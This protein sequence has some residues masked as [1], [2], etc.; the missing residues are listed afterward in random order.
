M[1]SK[2][3]RPEAVRVVVRALP[4]VRFLVRG[5]GRDRAATAPL[6]AEP[7]VTVTYAPL[8]VQ[9]EMIRR[10]ALFVGIDSGPR[11]VAAAVGGPVLGL[12]GPRPAA[13][14]PVIA[15]DRAITVDCPRTPCFEDNCSLGRDCL[16]TLDPERIAQTMREMLAER[17]IV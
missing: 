3:W 8:P 12:Y 4:G 9:A 2:W 6:A 16:G 14:L 7:N 15:G 11:Q 17:G 10:A 1:L 5:Y 13:H